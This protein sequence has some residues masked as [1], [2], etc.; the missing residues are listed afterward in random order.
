MALGLPCAESLESHGAAGVAQAKGLCH[1]VEGLAHRV[2]DRSAEQ[3]VVAPG[4]HVDEHGVPAGDDARHEGWLE[5]RGLE[6]VGHEVTLEVVHGN[7]RQVS[8]RTKPLGKGHAHH[9]RANQARAR[10]HAHG[11][12]VARR[13]R[14]HAKVR[15]GAGKRLLEDADDGLGVLARGNLGHHATK[16]RVEVDLRGHDARA[17]NAVSVRHGHGRLVAGGL[18]REDE[19]AGRGKRSLGG[20][21]AQR[22]LDRPRA[23]G[24]RGLGVLVGA[25][26]GVGS[27]RQL[28]AE[29]Q[30]IVRGLAGGR[31][32]VAA[33]SPL[34]RQAERGVERASGRVLGVHLERDRVRT[35]H[36]RVIGNARDEA[37]RDAL[38]P[39]RRVHDDLLDL[40]VGPGEVAPR[41]AD[42]P[43]LVVRDPPAAAGL[44]ELLVEE[45]LAPRRVGR[46]LV[47]GDLERGNGR[48]VVE[49]HR[50]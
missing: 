40:E 16:A 2:V 26:H 42:D 41:E 33:P 15:S 48:S 29:D 9:E 44:G 43:A 5:V 38:A 6:E 11:G 50:S 21:I 10:R 32:V 30:R 8:G 36:L 35:K 31:G 7:E 49:R 47:G 20:G 24:R 46:A 12:E 22:G 34:L 27:K 19:R 14:V 17:D 37:P 3:D 18:D 45:P 25:T 23:D 1:L 39:A 28:R 13:E 4:A